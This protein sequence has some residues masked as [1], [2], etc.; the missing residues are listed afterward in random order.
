MTENQEKEGLRS[1]KTIIVIV[2]EEKESGRSQKANNCDRKQKKGMQ[3]VTKKFLV[4][5]IR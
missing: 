5:G 3:T 1:Q 2:N 4:T